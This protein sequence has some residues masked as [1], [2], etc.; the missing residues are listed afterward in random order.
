MKPIHILILLT[1][2]LLAGNSS[3]AQ[4]IFVKILDANGK[5][6]PGGATEPQ[7]LNE[8]VAGSFGQENTGCALSSGGTKGGTC[9]GTAGHFIFNTT[10][11]QSYP[12]LTQAL[13]TGSVLKSVDIVFRKAGGGATA[14]AEF[15][16]IHLESVLVSHVT[17]NEDGTTGN[18][19]M[20]VELDA[21][22]MGWTYYPQTAGGALGTPVKFG[23]N[24][25]TKSTWSF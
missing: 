24:A 3:N 9:G 8:I 15:Y 20:Q 18:I 14:G 2:I 23:W 13:F 11:D 17:N 12:L 19:Q 10:L 21:L 4:T 7:H 5:L 16:K 6:M 25:E 22:K 1:A